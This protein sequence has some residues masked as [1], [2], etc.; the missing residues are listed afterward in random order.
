MKK[1]Y[2]LLFAA[3][4]CWM[5][6]TVWASTVTKEEA[7]Q[8]AR[9]FLSAKVQSGTTTAT[10][11]RAPSTAL[12]GGQSTQKQ[13]RNI[14]ALSGQKQQKT[15]SRSGDELTLSPNRLDPTMK[16]LD[17][18]KSLSFDYFYI[19][20]EDDADGG[21]V[22][23]AAD[24][25]VQP[26]L[27]Y[28]KTGTFDPDP[29]H[30]PDNLKWWLGMYNQ[31]I[32]TAVTEKVSASDEVKEEWTNL[33]RGMRS[34]TQ[35]TAVVGPLITTK[36]DQGSPYNGQCP[37]GRYTG[38]VA[39]AM[40]QVMNYYEWPQT[41][42]GSH[43]Y[44]DSK[45]G[46]SHNVNFANTTYDWSNMPEPKGT[47]SS[48]SAQKNAVATL[49]YHCGV[50][51][52]MSYG[53]DGSGAQTLPLR[54]GNTTSACAM[55]A[56]WNYFKYNADS[57]QANVRSSTGTNYSG[58]SS[59]TD[60]NWINMLKTELNK[61]RPI[62]YS[63]F[64]GG[65]GHSF[66]CDG[67]DSDGYFHFN[68]G[69]SGMYDNY[70]T[71]NNLNPGT[72]GAGSGEGTYNEGQGVIIGIV[73]N[74]S[75]K[76]TVTYNA[77]SHATCAT[78]SQTQ[79]TIGQSLTLP[80]ISNL[81]DK[82]LFLGWSDREGSQTPN[83]GKPGDSYTP[84]RNLTLYAV[85]VPD[86]YVLR[87]ISTINLADEVTELSELE[88]APY[89]WSDLLD[90]I[91][92]W[93]G[94]GTCDVDSLRE[95]EKGAGIV[96]PTASADGGF[97][98]QQWLYL[99]S[100]G[101]LY[102]AGY[103]G[104]RVYPSSD[105][106]LYGYWT[107][108]SK[109]WLDY[110]LTGVA[111]TSGPE[112]GWI[113]QADGV[114]ATFTAEKFFATLTNA[115]TTVTV[116]V[117]GETLS[118]SDYTKSFSA[119]VLTL[120]IAASKLSG[121][122][123]V[124]IVATENYSACDAY[125]F[126]YSNNNTTLLGTGTKTFSNKS[127]SVTAGGSTSCQYVNGSGARFGA[128]NATCSSLTYVTE[129][130][131]DCLIKTITV[132]ARA[133]VSGTI[134]AFIDG[135]SLGTKQNLTTS[136]ADYTFTNSKKLH[137]TVKF[138]V[139]NTAASTGNNRR[140]LYVK[141]INCSMY[142]HVAPQAPIQINV[143][144]V[145]A[146][147]LDYCEV[148]LETDPC[149]D[150]DWY[151]SFNYTSGLSNM[152]SNTNT[153]Y[154]DLTI[155]VDET[156]S[157]TSLSGTYTPWG[158][159]VDLSASES[160][161]VA[162]IVEPLT[163]TYKN[164]YTK[165]GTTYYVYHVTCRFLATDGQEYY[166]DSDV[167][168][169][170]YDYSEGTEITPTGDT[171]ARYYKAEHYQQNLNDDNY[172]LFES[173]TGNG[174]S[175]A[176]I[177]VTRNYYTG[178]LTPAAQS[179]TLANGNTQGNPAVVKYYYDRRTYPV[180]FMANNIPVQ[181]DTLRY[182]ATPA[183]R[184][185]TPIH[186]S[187]TDYVYT[188]AGWTPII[189]TVKQ[190]ATYTAQFNATACYTVS[191]NVNDLCT[192]PESQR[193]YE[194]QKATRPA[195]PSATGYDFGG[196]YTEPGCQNEWNFNTAITATITLYAKWTAHTHSLTWNA[197]GGSLSGGT[198][199]T[200]AYGT[201]IVQPTATRTGYTF[202][203]WDND[204]PA[205]MPDNDLSFTA[206]WNPNTNTPYV[207]KHYK[208]NIADNNYTEV[209]AD[210]QN[211]T[212]TTATSVTPAVKN[213]TGF[214]AP[215]TQTKAILADGS[216]VI[217]YN[218]DRN[219]YT[220]TWDA[221][222]GNIA[223]TAHTSGQV[224]FEAPI[225]APANANVTKT[226]Y[227]FTNWNPTP[228][229]TM[230]AANTT[231]TAQWSIKTYTISFTSE[232][233]NKGT[234]S[235]TGQKA[236]Y[237][238]GDIVTIKATPAAGYH[239]N[240]WSDNNTTAERTLTVGVDV[241]SSLVA[242]FSANTNTKYTV[243]FWKQNILND[244]YT[245]QTPA[246]YPRG[247]TGELTDALAEAKVYG[248]FERLPFEEKIIAGDSSTV[249]DIYYNR[250]TYVIRFLNDGAVLQNETLRYE[251][252]PIYN[253]ATPTK[254]ADAQYTYSFSGWEPTIYDVDKAQDYVAAFNKTVNKYDVSFNANGHGSA[255]AT[256]N[257]AF[258]SKVTKP[259]D[260]SETGWT[261]GGWYK[262]A[263]CA[264]AWDF[265]NETVTGTLELFAKWTINSHKVTWDAGEG[266]IT[267]AD[268]AYTHGDKID[269]GTVIVAPTVSRDGYSLQ[270]WLPAYTVGMT[271]PDNDMNFVAQWV[272]AGNTHYEVKHYKQNLDG[273]YDEEHPSD[274][275]V[276]DDGAADTEVTPLRKTY[277]GFKTPD[278]QTETILANGK[279]VVK[280]YYER[281]SYS[282][283]WNADGG[284]LV[285]N[286]YTRGSVKYEAPITLARAI[287]S[288]DG[289][290]LNQLPCLQTTI[291]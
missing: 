61:K 76:Y 222:G 221:N 275:D 132:N 8:L 7:A 217:T 56:L 274:T 35:A 68:W 29:S 11:K 82:W 255:P 60:A 186:E 230:P 47:S 136:A 22:I 1:I 20:Q 91:P 273:S 187:S 204:V 106:N 155:V 265:D 90:E 102:I 242:S 122:V 75:S 88:G 66:I 150:Y 191:F 86:G 43:S 44:T 77:G 71:V 3:I 17:L 177:E 32:K 170:M 271:M 104:D 140:Y 139:T 40:S 181:R 196:W 281:N 276:F 50:A 224:K 214:T 251:A 227:N 291:R 158:F 169:K 267:S 19:I 203:G 15:A 260:P 287:P 31:Q 27:A 233:V 289:I 24:D 185:A 258:G 178:F 25:A 2:L 218:Y 171:N 93:N 179:V 107:D 146:L 94:H 226:G 264:N 174:E 13:L 163:F 149:D 194:G 134:Q 105:M 164:T 237:N 148:F 213:Y 137:G 121:D 87:F 244:E 188:F 26:I 129:D 36:W 59:W 232:D 85:V 247:T 192:A 236:T 73:P 249:V 157:K 261:F 277:E 180:T 235:V 283:T 130:F 119:G 72:G 100:N 238:Y 268:G 173:V 6:T 154:P 189:T 272:V 156:P 54:Y 131:S 201:T 167:Y 41:G 46:T 83:V 183:Y 101:R 211:L 208:Q 266:T 123:E 14:D 278:A 64:G 70:F 117:D 175:G 81:E 98:F 39:T 209:E 160:V 135:D 199:G 223:G 145:Q 220:L 206:Q 28:G 80:N 182:Q 262:E 151:F 202:A 78:T 248:G 168:A 290:R 254:T 114:S 147:Y 216:L 200:V 142:E 184:G 133:G 57:L 165:S 279:L 52:E 115:N 113:T 89:Y 116:K 48:S 4:T 228:E 144:Y 270:G 84:M 38:C 152:P 166:L 234:V 21:W 124:T 161:S 49:M 55:N 239:F 240:K 138:V 99:A 162:S 229:S 280:Y 5:S 190:A 18:P 215:S 23:M 193:V 198:S 225:T 257:L 288:S 92:S 282:L 112:D 207:V 250:L 12:V 243:K 259:V 95:T 246:E 96:L 195:D 159:I 30:M 269:Y 212:G 110:Y 118:A 74:V 63:G 67:Y 10:V 33:R 58:Y 172:T 284:V 62:L 231:Y 16:V 9:S 69:W 143:D 103:P 176:T 241:T 79:S 197:N 219:S 128:N 286:G 51:V 108:D 141:S 263:G 252:T 53:T 42:Q 97:T 111:K 45:S 120:T 109:V 37:S 285:D 205:T 127:W 153:P 125:T 245:E 65:S 256:V 34:A 126:T 253:G 210:R